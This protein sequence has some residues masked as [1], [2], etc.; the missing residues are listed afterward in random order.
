MEA[1]DWKSTAVF[2]MD[3]EGS[4]GS[5]VVEYGVVRLLGGGIESVETSLC[6]PIGRISPRDR[7]VHGIRESAV[8]QRKP[9]RECYETFVGYR[10][11]GIFAAHN[12]HAENTFIKDTWALPPAVPDWRNNTASAQEWGP[13]IDT[14]SI[15]RALYPGLDSYA[16]GDL[17][18]TFKC[19]N[20]L[21]ELAGRHCPRERC[22]PHCALYDALAS[23][24]LL[25]RLETAE[26]FEGKITTR[27]LLQLSE[28]RDG[29]PELF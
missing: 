17:V 18:E 12:R 1:A 29:Q 26:S 23:A 28:A 13:W 20:Q 16:L 3:F 15:Y 5:G 8:A 27:W 4:P 25:L 19:R 14:L 24:V 11:E 2:M 10:R 9:F 7:E 22:K 6:R 21:H